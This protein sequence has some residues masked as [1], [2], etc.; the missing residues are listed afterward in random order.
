MDDCDRSTCNFCLRNNHRSTS[1]L[2]ILPDSREASSGYV[3]NTEVHT[4]SKIPG[5]G[6]G[7]DAEDHQLLQSLLK[8]QVLFSELSMG[9][10]TGLDGELP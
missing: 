7:D 4:T 3:S 6:T 5:Q 2:C 8:G 9:K 1:Y 10:K